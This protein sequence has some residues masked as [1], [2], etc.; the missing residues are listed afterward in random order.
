MRDFQNQNFVLHSKQIVYN[1]VILQQFWQNL[2]ASLISY[3][4]DEILKL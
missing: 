1:Q 4:T 2:E 3:V